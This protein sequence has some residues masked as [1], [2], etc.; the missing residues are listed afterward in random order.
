MPPTAYISNSFHV[1]NWLCAQALGI[2]NVIPA[3][4]TS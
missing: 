1:P 4:S 2:D 3:K